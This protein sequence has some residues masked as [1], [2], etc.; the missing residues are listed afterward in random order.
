[1]TQADNDLREV[2]TRVLRFFPTDSDMV[3]LGWE[4]SQIDAAC[5][6][7]DEARKVLG[8][9]PQIVSFEM[10]DAVTYY[11]GV[12]DERVV[13]SQG[14]A[15]ARDSVADRRDTAGVMMRAH[16]LCPTDLSHP[17]RM[18]WIA[19]YYETNRPREVSRLEAV[20]VHDAS[21]EDC[22]HRRSGERSS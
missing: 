15:A 20:V 3:E 14:G 21:A 8:T 10:P 6:A 13:G 19:D 22:G 1:M 17:K 12:I 9:A 7:V 11:G 16:A 2:L 4:K 5:D 18:K